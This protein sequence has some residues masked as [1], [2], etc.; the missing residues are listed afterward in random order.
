MQNAKIPANITKPRVEI[1][2]G[3]LYGTRSVIVHL[4][5]IFPS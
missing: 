2:W 3:H 5:K 4:G 1:K